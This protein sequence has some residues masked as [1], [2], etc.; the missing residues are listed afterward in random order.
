MIRVAHFLLVFLQIWKEKHKDLWILFT[1]WGRIGGYDAGQYQ[2]T[3]YGSAEQAI[4]E[5]EKV[6]KVK[7]NQSCSRQCLELINQ[8]RQRVVMNGKTEQTLKTNP[9]DIA[10]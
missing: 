3:P 4:E 9:K 5:F 8:F 2:N 1:N 6:F 7:P 10:W